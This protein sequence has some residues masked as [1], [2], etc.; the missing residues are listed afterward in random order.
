MNTLQIRLSKREQN[1]K[2]QTQQNNK[3]QNQRWARSIKGKRK[4]KTEVPLPN[5]NHQRE[6][7]LW[8][9]WPQAS[10]FDPTEQ[11]NKTKRQPRAKGK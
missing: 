1:N 11:R 4:I 5:S 6:L 2:Q 3:Q 10:E 7:F 9:N 8:E